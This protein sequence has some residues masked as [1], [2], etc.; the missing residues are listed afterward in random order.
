M[1]I[2]IDAKW[3]FTGPIS[4]RVITRNLLNE[5]VD[6][7]PEV[8]WHIFLKNSDRKFQRPFDAFNA[9]VHYIWGGL[10]MLSNLLVLPKLARKLRLDATL[11][12]TFN[13]LG[14]DSHSVVFIHDVLFTDYPQYFSW[15]EKLY[16]RPL[17]TTVR[18]AARVITTT[19]YVRQQ[20]I[21]FGYRK[22]E[23]PID[24][25]PCGVSGKFKP[26][27]QQNTELVN[28]VKEKYKLPEK[29]ILFVGRL[30]ERKNVQSLIRAMEFLNDEKI[31]LVITGEKDWKVPQLKNLIE[32]KHL[33]SR[34]IFTGA[35][36]DDEL[37]VIYALSRVFCFPSFAEGFGIPPLEA[38]ASGIP[39]VVSETTAMPEVCGVAAIYIDPY[40][41]RQIAKAIANLLENQSLREQKIHQGLEWAKNY[42][43][44]RMAAAVMQSISLAIGT[45]QI[46]NQFS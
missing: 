19:D 8:E 26:L 3:Y 15:Q 5:L 46:E 29:Y 30:N 39:V 37:P 17:K 42:T 23:Q 32:E 9:K 24:L 38:M 16:F 45:S 31:Y 27:P 10:N 18:T 22:K 21:N 4:G 36:N 40:D 14:Q 20:L 2:G 13:P 33:A 11:F 6:S 43:W 25:A 44:K 28:T 7:Y 1:K 41:P 34:I 12:Q 35:V